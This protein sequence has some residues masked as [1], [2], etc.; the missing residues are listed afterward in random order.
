LTE[1]N[2][3]DDTS[4]ILACRTDKRS[5]DA[6]RLLRD[7][8]FGDVRELRGGIERWNRNGLPAERRTAAASA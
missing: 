4:V 2:A 3:L 1:I 5:T 7:A 8:G 6:V